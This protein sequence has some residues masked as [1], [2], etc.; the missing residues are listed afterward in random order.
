[1]FCSPAVPF[2]KAH[3]AGFFVAVI[4]QS[5]LSTTQHQYQVK[6]N[7]QPS[8]QARLEMGDVAIINFR[9]MTKI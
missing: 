2:P 6:Q 4:E 9:L 7:C 3:A 8:T 1:M 5:K